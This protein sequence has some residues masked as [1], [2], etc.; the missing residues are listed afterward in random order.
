MIIKKD[1]IVT[2]LPSDD[3]I[4]EYESFWRL[5]LPLSYLTF[6]KEYNGVEVEDAVFLC[7]NREYV[8]ER[9]LCMI[10]DIESHPKGHYD[11][12]VVLSQIGERL[13]DNDDLLGAEV[14]PIANV[15][16]GDMVCLDFRRNKQNPS[17]CVWSHEESDVLEPVFYKITN[18]FSAFMAML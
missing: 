11:I 6:I 3:L 15:F 5:D 16:A 1:S 10:D 14:L 17:V 12:D 18:D 8:I 7:N 9:F 4:K 2:P 13:T